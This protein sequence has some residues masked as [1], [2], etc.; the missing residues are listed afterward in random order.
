MLHLVRTCIGDLLDLLYPL[1]GVR[2]VVAS[3]HPRILPMHRLPDRLPGRIITCFRK[4]RSTRR[5]TGQF[6]LETATSMF[7]F[8]KDTPVQDMLHR[9]K[10]P[11]T[12]G[13]RL[14]TGAA[15]RA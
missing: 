1:S 11:G 15:L 12:E 4:I 5:F 13:S 9:I 8:V 7:C 3:I 6:A 10:V 14:V 2:P